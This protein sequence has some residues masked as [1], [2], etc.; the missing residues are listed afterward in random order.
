MRSVARN[1][2]GGFPRKWAEL[3]DF[4]SAGPCLFFVGDLNHNFRP[5]G[6]RSRE[7]VRDVVERLAAA[8]LVQRLACGDRRGAR[9]RKPADT[10]LPVE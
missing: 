7:R 5:D 10:V 4:L 9:C 1:C 8:G 3:D 6:T 2:A